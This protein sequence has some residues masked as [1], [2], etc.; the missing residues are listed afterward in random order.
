MRLRKSPAVRQ[1]PPKYSST[2]FS[3]ITVNGNKL[4]IYDEPCVLDFKKAIERFN[5]M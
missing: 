5:T 4:Y 2:K 3:A 1:T